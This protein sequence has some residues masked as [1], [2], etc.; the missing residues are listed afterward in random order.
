[1]DWLQRQSIQMGCTE[2]LS[3]ARFAVRVKGAF[4]SYSLQLPI[5]LSAQKHYDA[6]LR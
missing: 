3:S 1:M 6:R 5:P 2:I 4:N